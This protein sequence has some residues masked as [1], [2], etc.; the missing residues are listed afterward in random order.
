MANNSEISNPPIIKNSI[1]NFLG[2]LLPLLI[3]LITIPY[4]I[5][6]LGVDRFG[7]LLLVWTILG[8]FTLFD[9]G[10][11]RTVIKFISQLLGERNERKIPAYFWSIIFLQMIIGIVA[12]TIF[13]LLSA[14]LVTKVFSIPPNL[15]NE[16]Q[17][18][19]FVLSAVLPL[20]LLS[21]SFSGVLQACQR[22]DL[23]NFINVP[24]NISLFVI[25]LVAALF[26]LNLLGIMWLI[27][28]VRIIVLIVF[29]ML[30]TKIL[31]ILKKDISI[32][33]DLLREIF[34]F[35]SWLNI[36]SIVAPL[37]INIERFFIASL[38]A[39]SALTYYATVHEVVNRLYILPGSIA[40]SLFPAVSYMGQQKSKKDVSLI[41]L[42]LLKFLFLILFPIVLIIVFF[43][44]R[45]IQ[46]WIGSDFAH[47]S[48]IVFQILIIGFLFSSMGWLPFAIF[49]GLGKPDIPAKIQL[50]HLILAI[51]F[52]YL[53][54]SHWGILGAALVWA[55][56]LSI[57]A[58]LFVFLLA[59]SLNISFTM[60]LKNGF[61]EIFSAGCVISIIFIIGMNYLDSL[62][63]QTTFAIIALGLFY[64]SVWN[65]AL[66]TD[67]RKII[68]TSI[69]WIK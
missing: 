30:S 39:M 61:K 57:E 12:G 58:G 15:L 59:R 60:F 64:I 19:F 48:S 34:S 47:H 28:T 8:F 11:S 66:T 14:F 5:S 63:L 53:A 37:L 67:E 33:K 51:P 29:I 62:G 24:A 10:L 68:Y 69:R 6:T 41:Y 54:I 32:R 26:G 27:A 4:L 49:Q 9:I 56:R 23:L 44:E 35:A 52:V 65:Y 36:S 13:F 17:R 38:L 1:I 46:L 31:P 20:T 7:I 42:R 16:T 18:V 43:T 40:M 21:L 50:I 45:I 2:Q 22:F 55:S 25:P 3:G